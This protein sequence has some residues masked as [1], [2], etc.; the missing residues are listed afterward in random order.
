MENGN[1]KGNTS[2][3]QSETNALVGKGETQTQA[4]TSFGTMETSIEEAILVTNKKNVEITNKGD[5]KEED[6][7]DEVQPNMRTSEEERGGEEVEGN[8]TKKKKFDK[9]RKV[10]KKIA[11]VDSSAKATKKADKPESSKKVDSAGMIFMCSSKTKKDCYRYKVLGLPANKKEVVRKIYKGMRLFL[12]DFD[13]RLM[14]GI[15]KATRPGGYNIEPKAFKSAFPS[16]VS[17]HTLELY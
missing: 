2:K 12:F 11:L 1:N 7:K 14:Y 8:S 17:V 16:Q 3:P 5:G 6:A 10:S 15:Y 9:R 13:L 4:T